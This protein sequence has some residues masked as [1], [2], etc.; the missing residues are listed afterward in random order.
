MKEE[1]RLK[2]NAL[3]F[4]SSCG[5]A[6]FKFVVCNSSDL[7][8]VLA[9]QGSFQIPSSR[10]YL[11]PEGRDVEALQERSLWLADI[12]RDHGFRFSPRLHVLLWGNQRAK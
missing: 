10:I 11:M 4:F 8:E 1:L 5:K 9:L 7:A 12:C 6:L 2:A 3:R